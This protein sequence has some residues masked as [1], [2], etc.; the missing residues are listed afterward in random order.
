MGRTCFCCDDKHADIKKDRETEVSRL[1][2]KNLLRIAKEKGANFVVDLV[3]EEKSGTDRVIRGEIIDCF[4][5]TLKVKS[6]DGVDRSK[7]LA[8]LKQGKVNPSV[9]FATLEFDVV[10]DCKS[11]EIKITKKVKG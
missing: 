10:E 6:L 9:G 11:L 8:V 7:L 5:K 4:K 3:E 2:R 1:A